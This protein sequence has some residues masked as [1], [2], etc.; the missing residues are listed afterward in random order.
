MVLHAVPDA[1]FKWSY[2]PRNKI[3]FKPKISNQQG[4]A[5]TLRNS[6]FSVIGPKLFNS[7]P[8]ELREL[9]D[10]QKTTEQLI[11]TFKKNI[12]NYLSTIPDVPGRA[13]SLLDH[14]GID[15]GYRYEKPSDQAT[16]T[17]KSSRRNNSRRYH[18]N[19]YGRLDHANRPTFQSRWDDGPVNL[20]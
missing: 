15:Y 6:S 17:T 18:N 5:H 13:N 4:W 20:L 7:L 9:P 3:T 10:L 12:D 11:S 19:N 1:G 8:R 2:C 16:N 14:E